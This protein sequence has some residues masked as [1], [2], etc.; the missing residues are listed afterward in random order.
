M[1]F[2]FKAEKKSQSQREKSG[3]G[4]KTNDP[5]TAKTDRLTMKWRRNRKTLRTLLG[6]GKLEQA[7]KDL[8]R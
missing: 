2:K 8:E 3:S 7:V 4:R 5:H 6:A 1:K